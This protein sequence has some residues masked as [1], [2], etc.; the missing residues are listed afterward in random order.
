MHPA[1]T[2]T[3]FSS[4]N[5]LTQQRLQQQLQQK[6]YSESNILSARE[7]Q[8]HSHDEGRQPHATPGNNSNT[9]QHNQ[10]TANNMSN[11][12]KLCNPN[13]PQSHVWL[14]AYIPSYARV[15]RR[16]PLTFV[17]QGHSVTQ[18]EATHVFNRGMHASHSRIRAFLHSSQIPRLDVLRSERDGCDPFWGDLAHAG[19]VAT[20]AIT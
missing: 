2:C 8:Q 18:P 11:T 3:Q 14:F 19:C 1:C 4:S 10:A 20:Q 7:S 16:T 9:R 12:R 5:R 6:L 15:T 17:M 13:H